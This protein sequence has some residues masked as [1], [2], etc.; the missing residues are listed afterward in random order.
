MLRKIK[1]GLFLGLVFQLIFILLLTFTFSQQTF[2]I[3]KKP[4]RDVWIKE[5]EN[6]P[7]IYELQ[8]KSKTADNYKFFSLLDVL[9][10]PSQQYIDKSVQTINLSIYIRKDLQPGKYT[11]TYYIKNSKE[12]IEDRFSFEVVNAKD[13][14]NF[15]V[16]ERITK[17]ERAIKLKIKNNFNL[18]FDSLTLK[19]YN[20]FIDSSFNISLKPFEEKEVEI[21]IK[22]NIEK[23]WSGYKDLKIEVIL[24]GK[25]YV[26]ERQIF[27]EEYK[28]IKTEEKIES[29]FLGK[30]IYIK[31]TNLGNNIVEVTI[32]IMLNSFE[33]I[34]AKGNIKASEI[35]KEKGYY[36]YVFK[37]DLKPNES[38][39][40]K[41][42]INYQ[43]LLILP[44]IILIII[45][46]LISRKE[47]VVIK[48][49]VKRVKT[50]SGEFALRVF[51]NVTNK[52][53]ESIKEVSLLDYLPLSL[54][55]YEYGL[56]QPDKIEGN[57]LY[58]VLGEIPA[59]ESRSIS[60]LCYSKIKYEGRVL[61]P[62]AKIKYVLR[63]KKY[64]K[65]SNMCSIAIEKEKE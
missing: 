30:K 41:V 54:K 20:N 53:K 48:K 4:I 26:F 62:R 15:S 56:T 32:P 25:S 22:E 18:A 39:E 17:D 40:V 10:Y 21:S 2:E 64:V 35:K 46:V 50:K 43:W 59:G 37:K 51:I 1:K 12:I 42:D 44:I 23:E 45:I 6:F 63:G 34:F 16:P 9:I 29:M 61:L 47:E 60:Y 55:F 36:V 7:L 5:F 33:K 38:F 58:W 13:I 24:Y 28:D 3:E 65:E 14:F 57:K 31:K 52:T 49:D 19:I 8:I 11:Y 27:L